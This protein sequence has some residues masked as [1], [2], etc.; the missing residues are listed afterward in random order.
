MKTTN[1]LICSG[2]SPLALVCMLAAAFLLGPQKAGAVPVAIVNAS[3]EANVLADGAAISDIIGWSHSTTDGWGTFNP[4]NA[5]YAGTTGSP[6]T[7]PA[8]ADGVNVAYMNGTGSIY[9]TLT[10]TLAA[11]TTYT[12]TGALGWRLDFGNGAPAYAQLEAANGDVLATY[13]IPEPTQGT[14]GAWT[15]TFT[16]VGTDLGQN[17][18]I[19][20]GSLRPD[21][22]GQANFD[23]I[24]LDAS[25]LATPDG[26]T[27]VMLLGIALTGVGLFRRRIKKA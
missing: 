6:G 22:L 24:A 20:L 8:P 21:F 5:Q 15:L 2:G 10:A 23:N 12:L 17:I 14:F 7:L 26:G 11:N 27:T 1:R 9:Q 4:R 13:T 3:F 19:R 16:D 25:P 18:V